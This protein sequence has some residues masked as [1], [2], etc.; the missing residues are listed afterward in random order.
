L[1]QP[2]HSKQKDSLMRSPLK[3]L[4]AS[5]A[6]LVVLV[7]VGLLLLVV[8]VDPNDFKPQ[9]VAAAKQQSGRELRID[10]ELGWT[11]W[12]VLGIEVN[13]ASLANAAGFG[14]QPML[15]VQRIAVGVELLPLLGKQVN[16]SQLR[17]EQP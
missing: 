15:A 14:D 11:F 8:L 9:I 10:G 4:L 6:A 17:L 1:S 2:I 12:P 7:V 3:I 16:V 5:L 13:Q